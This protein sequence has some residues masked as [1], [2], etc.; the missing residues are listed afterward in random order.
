MF[1]RRKDKMYT[2]DFSG[3]IVSFPKT[4]REDSRKYLV[5]PLKDWQY[6]YAYKDISEVGKALKCNELLN[7]CPLSINDIE[8]A[9]YAFN[10]YTPNGK[11]ALNPC[12]L[13]VGLR[14]KAGI[15][16]MLTIK[17]DKYDNIK[18]ASYSSGMTQ[19]IGE[20][21]NVDLHYVRDCF[22]VTKIVKGQGYDW[23]TVFHIRK[24]NI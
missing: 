20:T 8:F 22:Y 3:K 2:V 15:P 19:P 7:D 18:T 13:I 1:F 5:F 6:Q 14:T 11:I 12:N 21:Y 17:Y 9:D 4:K 10:P 24:E 16:Y 23:E